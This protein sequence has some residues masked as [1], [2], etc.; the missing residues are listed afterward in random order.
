VSKDPPHSSRSTVTLSQKLLYLVWFTSSRRL[1]PLSM[2]C[3]SD[4]RSEPEN[5][6]TE[7][8]I[9]SRN[10][11]SL[12]ECHDDPSR[13]ELVD[14]H[15]DSRTRGSSMSSMRIEVY[16]ER[17][18]WRIKFYERAIIFAKD[19]F[20]SSSCRVSFLLHQTKNSERCRNRSCRGDDSLDVK[21]PS[22]RLARVASDPRS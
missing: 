15:L 6:A 5:T 1:P 7:I 11:F 14:F 10:R 22:S 13:R 8:Q 2:S 3:S 17:E 4:L 12:V 19:P 21:F 9:S 20:A 18:S 16:G